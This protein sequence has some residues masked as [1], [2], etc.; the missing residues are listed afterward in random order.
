[1]K[2]FIFSSVLSLFISI[3]FG[4]QLPVEP[5]VVEIEEM[6]IP[7]TPGTHSYSYAKDADG[8][9]LIIGGRIDGLHQRQPFAAFLEADNNKFAFVIDPVSQQTWSA[10][11]AV[12]PASIFEQLQ[13][14]NQEFYQRDSTLYIF[15]GYGYSATN[16]EHM[17]YP[18]ITAVDINSLTNSI[19]SG[20]SINS[21]FRQIMDQ[22]MKVTGGQIGMID[23]TFYL[24][25]GQLFDGSYNPMG[26]DHGP[27]FTQ[28]YT[29]A[30]REFKIADDGTNFSIY[31]YSE[32]FDSLNLHR[33]DYNMAYQIF[34]NGDLG[35]TVF[36]GVFDPNDL[37]YLNT[38][39]ITEASGYQVNN[40]F[41]QYLSQYHS[42][43]IPIYDS[44]ALSTQ[45]LFFGGMSQFYYENGALIEDT[46]V[47]FVKTV[48]KV[49]RFNTGDMQEDVL[50]YLEMPA[51]L[52]AGAEF[53]PSGDYLIEE[54]LI[55]INAI[56]NQ[57]TLIGY[58][59][60]GIESS[61]KNIFFVNNGTQSSAS[62]TIFKVYINK[63]LVG[64]EEIEITGSEIE[65]LSVYPNPSKKEITIS[66]VVQN[67]NEVSYEIINS[68]GKT[69]KVDSFGKIDT[70]IYESKVDISDLAKG[71]YVLKLN[72]G[73]HKIQYKFVK[74]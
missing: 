50:S 17:T 69:C 19:I 9:W 12:L 38:V 30:I 49:T 10:D 68:Q 71:N 32:T 67:P 51:L 61:D 57:K 46:D 21:H 22:N 7:N 13:S 58:I 16:T 34:P 74:K 39:D 18:N 36:S 40:S 5:Y 43:K 23:S 33:R 72:S 6:V 59:Y 66:F 14:T 4:Q 54:H 65:S 1:M 15:G 60:G 25:G 55:D 47:P 3:G 20:S 56:P 11:L 52:G 63:S 35:F 48:S 41:N 26:P 44:A 64:Y 73:I 53:I 8:K 42:A 27:G 28:T 45:T 31:D 70:G 2:Q 29:N 62:N 37:P 24:V